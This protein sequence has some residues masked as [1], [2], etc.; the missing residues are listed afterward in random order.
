MMAMRWNSVCLYCS[1]IL[2]GQLD[3]TTNCLF[4][5]WMGY[6]ST[7]HPLLD[8]HATRVWC[9]E[10]GLTACFS[11]FKVIKLQAEA[12]PGYPYGK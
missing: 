7:G 8:L 3:L 4:S 12:K 5:M 10:L 11:L 6:V 2:M 9:F 1:M